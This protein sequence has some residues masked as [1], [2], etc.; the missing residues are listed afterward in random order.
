MTLCP[1][2][3]FFFGQPCIFEGYLIPFLHHCLLLCRYVMFQKQYFNV[4]QTEIVGERHKH[5]LGG[6]RPPDPLSN[7]TALASEWNKLVFGIKWI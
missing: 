3:Q 6:A 4:K 1:R 7:G 5:P 2:V